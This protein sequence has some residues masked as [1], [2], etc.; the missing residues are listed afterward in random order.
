MEST[1]TIV[2]TVVRHGQTEANAERV[3][4]GQTDT[5][6]NDMGVKQGHAAGQALKTTRFDKAFSS[7]LQRA[8]NTCS[9]I[10]EENENSIHDIIEDKRL[11]ERHF[12]ELENCSMASAVEMTKGKTSSFFMDM[13]Y[14]P[15]GGESLTDVRDR[16][17]SFLNVNIS[18]VLK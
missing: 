16:A 12:G 18:T 15:N 13:N 1:K 5:C 2:L 10:L 3:I 14:K 9:Y 6:L 8:K 11:R 17:R 7:D 4:H